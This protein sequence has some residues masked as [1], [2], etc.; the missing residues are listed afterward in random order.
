MSIIRTL[1]VLGKEFRLGPRSPVFL[2]V[3]F[4]PVLFTLILQVTFGSLFDPKPR[5]GIVDQGTSTITTAVQGMEGIDLALLNDAEELK[6]QV[7]ANDLDA[8]LVLP[9]GFDALV[10]AGDR[11][12]LEFYVGGESLA[13][14]RIILAV[15][16]VDL[17]REIEGT[18]PPVD[19]EVVALGDEGLP[20]EIRLVPFI[21]MY[22]LVVAA[23]FLPAMSIADEREKGTLNALIVT[24]VKLGEVITAKGMLGV[25]LALAMTLFTLFLNNALGAEP[26]ALFLVIL[27]GAILCAE[28][29]LIFGAVSKDVNAVFALIKGTGILLIGPTAFYIWPDWPQWIAK[30]FPTYWVINP[31]F[32][33]SLNNATLGDVWVEMVVA[34]GVI[35]LLGLVIAAATRR[36]RG[37]LASAA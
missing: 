31:I 32:E 5:L 24:P 3:L 4:L 25:V 29:G 28:I 14:N 2:W 9:S 27:L 12:P 37:L 15:T 26:L 18:P 34:I 10:R 16:T 6:A 11:P 30:I 7:E 21:M 23:V 20:I 22:A 33:V 13:F 8:G 35:G 19:V 36:L 1:K 17:V